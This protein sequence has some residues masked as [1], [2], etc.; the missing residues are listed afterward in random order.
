MKP[1]LQTDVFKT[2]GKTYFETYTEA[3]TC[4]FTCFLAVKTFHFSK[5]IK[6]VDKIM[7]QQI[8][9]V[10]AKSYFLYAYYIVQ[11]IV[12]IAKLQ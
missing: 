4:P 7:V 10:V 9:F 12:S 6:M 11:I 3:T 2:K 5:L 8:E 1:V